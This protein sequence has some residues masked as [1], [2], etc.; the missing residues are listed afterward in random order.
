MRFL[1]PGVALTDEAVRRAYLAGWDGIPWPSQNRWDGETFSI[2][3]STAES[4]ALHIP[5]EV[6]GFGELLLSTASL[7]ERDAHYLLPVE[8]ARG[9]VSR[10]REQLVEWMD[11]G[12]DPPADCRQLV[13]DATEVFANAATMQHDLQYASQTAQRAL[14]MCLAAVSTLAAVYARQSL[15]S[16]R[17]QYARLPTL[18]AVRVDEPP[19][20][21]MEQAVCE[22]F[23]WAAPAMPWNLIEGNAD[24]RDWAESDRLLQWCEERKMR[25]CAGPLIRLDRHSLPEWVYLWEDD[26]EQLRSDAGR[27]LQTIV[28]RYMGRVHVWHAAAGLNVGGALKLSEEHRLKLAF[29][30]IEAIRALDRQTPVIVSFDQPWGE[31]LTDQEMELTPFHFADAL[32][33]ADVGLSGIGLTMHLGYWPDGTPPRDLLEINRQVDRWSMLNIP[34]LI[35]LAVPSG[36]KPEGASGL[37]PL[38]KFM[39]DGPSPAGQ[40]EWLGRLLPMLVAKPAVHGVIWSQLSDAR[41]PLT[42]GGLFDGAGQPKPALQ[43]ITRF[44]KDY[45]A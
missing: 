29:R 38:P 41:G 33:R 31:Y 40:N 26:F 7:M 11:A 23:P 13:R 24:Q 42:C 16:R 10:L 36:A 28:Q 4:G 17:S 19:S 35:T 8:L 9:A 39:A 20:M 2:E 25:I 44:R 45:L 27:H 3:R 37:S 30:C 15:E 22:A 5:W 34:L 18:L 32:A 14:E 1:S 6:A 12:V 21:D 43:T